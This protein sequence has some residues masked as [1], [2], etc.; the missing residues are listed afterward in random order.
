MNEFFDGPLPLIGDGAISIAA[1]KD[2][3]IVSTLANWE[4][5]RVHLA[6]DSVRVRLGDGWPTKVEKVVEFSG[7]VR[8]T[9]MEFDPND[10]PIVDIK[11]GPYLVQVF[12]RSVE[13]VAQRPKLQV[14][15][16]A[17]EQHLVFLSPFR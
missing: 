10:S 1:A 11:P 17:M 12:A 2:L 7:P 3:A 4:P 5:V 8:V 13:Y 14:D 15:D 6:V 16:V 9:D